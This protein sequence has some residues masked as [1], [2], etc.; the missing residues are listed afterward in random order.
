M[1]LLDFAG[2]VGVVLGATGAEQSFMVAVEMFEDVFALFID[3][4]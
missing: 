4:I 3:E 2:L 1:H